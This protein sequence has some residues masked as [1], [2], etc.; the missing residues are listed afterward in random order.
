M[1]KEKVV[2]VIDVHEPPDITDEVSKHPEVED[3]NI[4]SDFGA[5]IEIA[6]VG[7]ERKTIGDYA[8]SLTE[9]RLE[10]QRFKLSQRY[11]YAYVLIDGNMQETRNLFKSS[12]DGTSIRGHM[13]SLTAREISGINA[14]IPCGNTKLLVDM[15][16]R[17]AR[18][19]VE[20]KNREYVPTD[21]VDDD[22][23]VA[24][25]VYCQL[26]N[27]GPKTAKKLHEKWPALNEFYENVTYE[28][29][30]EIEGIGENRALQIIGALTDEQ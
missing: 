15:A 1:T 13:A 22:T 11:E 16:I 25:K 12:L 14:V 19:H 27:V 6:G 28:S 18:K 9:G 29:L 10:E 17:L 30:K 8:S 26:P 24:I 7:F 20:D 5:D 23:P 4:D 3:F 21:E 2:V